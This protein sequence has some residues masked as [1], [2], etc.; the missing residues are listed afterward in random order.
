[1]GF[2]DVIGNHLLRGFACLLELAVVVRIDGANRRTDFT[3]VEVI[4]E[5]VSNPLDAFVFACIAS[6]LN[7][8]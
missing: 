4:V 7:F 1:M 6:G 8:I 3:A 2:T 5:T